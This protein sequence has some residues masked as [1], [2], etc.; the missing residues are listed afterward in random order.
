MLE[1]KINGWEQAG[2]RLLRPLAL[3]TLVLGS[4]YLTSCGSDPQPSQYCCEAKKCGQQGN[5]PVCDGDGD[6][7]YCRSPTCCEQLNCPDDTTCSTGSIGCA[8]FD[9]HENEGY[10]SLQQGST[11]P[12]RAS[13]D[14]TFLEERK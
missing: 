4:S 12:V 8:C 9:R 7:C 6:D 1:N 3:T 11:Y 13:S 2:K 5:P 10:R 14:F